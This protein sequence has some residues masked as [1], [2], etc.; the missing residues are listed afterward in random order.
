[1]SALSCA[2]DKDAITPALTFC[3]D[4]GG[5]LVSCAF[6]STFACA[7]ESAAIAA[8]GSCLNIVTGMALI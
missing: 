8:A 3:I 6:E 2:F 4:A 1:M 5:M 7:V